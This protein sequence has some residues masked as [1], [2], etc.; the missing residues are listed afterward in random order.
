MAHWI[1][2][3]VVL[4]RW[5]GSLLGRGFD[6][7]ARNFHVPQVQEKKK[8]RMKPADSSITPVHLL[9]TSL[10]HPVPAEEGVGKE[11]MTRP[12]S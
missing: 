4:L 12:G 6:P 7:W 2:D 5:L 11:V 1:K 10:P 3:L 9:G 8:K